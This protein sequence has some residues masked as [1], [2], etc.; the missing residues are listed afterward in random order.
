MKKVYLLLSCRDNGESNEWHQI[1]EYTVGIYSSL[2]L[3]MQKGKT[4]FEKMDNYWKSKDEELNEDPFF[5]DG[6]YWLE[7]HEFILDDMGA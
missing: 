7:I 5:K 6:W 2:E 1:N 4:S 3:A